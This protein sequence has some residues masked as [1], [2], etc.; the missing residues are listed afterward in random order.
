MDKEEFWD[1]LKSGKFASMVRESSQGKYLYS[2]IDV[3]NVMKPVFAEKDDIECMYCIFMNTKNKVI[4]IEKMSEG[5]INHS[6]FYPR[7]IVKRVIQL[8]AASII[9]LHN[10]PSGDP[11]PSVQDEKITM[12]LGMSLSS[13]DAHL[14]DHIIIGDGYYSMADNGYIMKIGDRV[15]E[16][17]LG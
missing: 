2:S 6:V 13:I 8:K 15:K 3:F 11:E 5:T 1:D 10:H 4:A 7:E 12:K 16:F 17:I 9:L 14:L